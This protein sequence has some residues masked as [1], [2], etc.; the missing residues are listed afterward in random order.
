V[1]IIRGTGLADI[2]DGQAAEIALYDGAESLAISA[3]REDGSS[4]ESVYDCIFF[5]DARCDAPG[6]LVLN[7][8]GRSLSVVI[9]RGFRPPTIEMP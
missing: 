7:C 1:Q 5:P 2:P 3:V 4:F 6:G 9:S 8:A